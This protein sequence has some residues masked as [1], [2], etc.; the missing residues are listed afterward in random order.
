MVAILQ[1][2]ESFFH[3][4]RANPSG[5]SQAHFGQVSLELA[6]KGDYSDI[7]NMS[8]INKKKNVFF[9]AFLF[10]LEIKKKT[11]LNNNA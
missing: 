10:F 8:Q 1:I 7:W 4:K 5:A 11:F 3:A 2:F 9:F 6:Q